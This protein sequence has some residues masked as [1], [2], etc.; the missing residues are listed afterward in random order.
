MQGDFTGVGSLIAQREGEER[1]LIE[2]AKA[3]PGA[4]AQVNG[5]QGQV[6][7]HR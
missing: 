3:Y 1:K 6:P 7:R 2:A 4:A 5:G